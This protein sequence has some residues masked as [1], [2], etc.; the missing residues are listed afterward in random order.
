MDKLSKLNG[1]FPLYKPENMTSADC[2]D[3]LKH[4]LVKLVFGGGSEDKKVSMRKFQKMCKVGHG[5]TLDPIATGV[6]V[7]GLGTGCK[8]LADALKGKKVYRF[9]A[10]LGTHFDTYDRTGQL[11]KQDEELLAGKKVPSEK[12][13]LQ[14]KNQFIGDILQRPPLYS[15]VH[16]NG[17]RAYDIARSTKDP[18]EMMQLEPKP[19]NISRIELL[20]Y[21]QPARELE[22]EMECGGGT[23]VRS[24][25][26]DLANALGTF[27]HM[28]ELVRT[29]QGPFK[30]E[31]CLRLENINTLEQ[32][33]SALC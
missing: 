9:K 8:R 2:L 3:K 1:I 26:V 19:V 17:K 24:L 14:A 12:E 32:I 4:L 6:L 25:I 22:M 7:V 33:K 31:E 16:V 13:I 15:A 20:A 27:G 10:K 29:Q 28:T 21:D 23:Y 11:L 18:M 30:L 5:G